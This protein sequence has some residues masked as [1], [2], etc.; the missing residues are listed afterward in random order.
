MVV[1]GTLVSITF[2]VDED[3][4]WREKCKFCSPI[5]PSPTNGKTA[6]K[7]WTTKQFITEAK[8]RRLL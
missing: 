6:F 4:N 7:C 8:K 2:F 1:G 5:K 3:G